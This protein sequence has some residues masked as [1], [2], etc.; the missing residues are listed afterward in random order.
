MNPE[1]TFNA[2]DGDRHLRFELNSKHFHPLSFNRR[3]GTSFS[4]LGKVTTKTAIINGKEE[5]VIDEVKLRYHRIYGLLNFSINQ[6]LK[7]TRDYVS[8]AGG[9]GIIIHIQL[10]AFN[11]REL[12]ETNY[13]VPN[14]VVVKKIKHTNPT[15]PN[16]EKERYDDIIHLSIDDEEILNFDEND[17]I[18]W[19]EKQTSHDQ[20]DI[21]VNNLIP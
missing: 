12:E 19:N 7:V 5:I 3:Y 17:D 6:V 9:E 18:Y 21:C 10:R 8:P 1:N 15:A 16:C 11:N 14:N 4:I 13:I 2:P 20:I